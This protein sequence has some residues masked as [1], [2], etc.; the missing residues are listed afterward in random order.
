MYFIA[1]EMITDA[2]RANPHRA[3]MFSLSQTL[4][5]LAT[6]QNYP[7]RGGVRLNDRQT[8][9]GAWVQ[10]PRVGSLDALLE[11][12]TADDPHQRPSF[13]EFATE[14]R[15]WL[16]GPPPKLGPLD[17]SGLKARATAL[18]APGIAAAERFERAQRATRQL[19]ERVYADVAR[20]E[21]SI[22]EALPGFV[23]GVDLGFADIVTCGDSRKFGGWSHLR[24]VRGFVAPGTSAFAL[25]TG[26]AMQMNGEG[27]VAQTN[28]LANHSHLG[29]PEPH[30][31]WKD[32]RTVRVGSAAA[33]VAV[34][35][36]VEGLAKHAHEAVAYL[37]D[38]LQ[39]LSTA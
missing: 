4:C 23:G 14:L 22:Q 24:D 29:I 3:D 37:L 30:I 18:V 36:Q 32:V 33:D 1:P 35:E 27:N 26:V 11:R 15:A 25:W 12:G 31:V 34:G 2:K 10:D 38:K 13:E 8:T 39:A 21:A 19:A 7:P 28:V 20:I 16:R 17:L 6:G 5:V 9:L